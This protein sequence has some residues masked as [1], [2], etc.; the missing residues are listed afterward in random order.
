MSGDGLEL[1]GT[2]VKY[3]MVIYEIGR[4]GQTVCSA[5]VAQR[6]EVSRPSVTRM[7]GVLTQKGLTVKERYGKIALTAEGWRV[8]GCYE[9]SIDNLARLLPQAGFALTPEELRQ[10]AIALAGALPARCVLNPPR[11]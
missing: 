9:S 2:H 1:S 8:A 7:L 5:Q 6:L 4:A 11:G 3:L 10:A